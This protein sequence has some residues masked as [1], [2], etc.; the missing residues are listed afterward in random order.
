LRAITVLRGKS[1][2]PRFYPTGRPCLPQGIKKPL[3]GDVTVP[4]P[5]ASRAG[6]PALPQERRSWVRSRTAPV[7]ALVV[8]S[9]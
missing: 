2:G 9:A 7:S 3:Q 1:H 8:I 4:R 5:Q 6:M